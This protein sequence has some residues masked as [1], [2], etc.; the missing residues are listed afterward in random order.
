MTTIDA[1][2]ISPESCRIHTKGHGGG[3]VTIVGK[4]HTKMLSVRVSSESCVSAPDL[5]ADTATLCVTRHGGHID[6]VHII[7]VGVLSLEHDSE[8]VY[9]RDPRCSIRRSMNSRGTIAEMTK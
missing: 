2:C 9:T 3:G 7:K 6:G 8:I 5:G 4:S 1:S